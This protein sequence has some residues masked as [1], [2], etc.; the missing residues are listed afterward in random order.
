MAA[1]LKILTLC[2][3][4]EEKYLWRV[5]SV[6]MASCCWKLDILF[7]IFA[8]NICFENTVCYVS[9]LWC[10]EVFRLVTR[11]ALSVCHASRRCYKCVQWFVWPEEVAVIFAGTTCLIFTIISSTEATKGR[12]AFWR[13][14]R[15][16]MYLWFLSF[17]LSL[18]TYSRHGQIIEFAT[19]MVIH[20]SKTVSVCF[21]HVIHA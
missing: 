21:C 3:V 4:S 18:R 12:S 8:E 16:L 5:V 15:A 9:D 6:N 7:L 11:H 13:S 17:F 19:M 2:D 10:D 14:R 20:M 1:V